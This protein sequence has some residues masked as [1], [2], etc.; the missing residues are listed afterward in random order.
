MMKKEIFTS[1]VFT[2]M[3]VEESLGSSA[4]PAVGD[5]RDTNKKKD[6]TIA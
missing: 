3:Q 6:S 5:A 1:F 4:R 2:K